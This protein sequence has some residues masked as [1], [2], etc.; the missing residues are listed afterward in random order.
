MTVRCSEREVFITFEIGIFIFQKR[1]DSLQGAFIHPPE[2][3]EGRFVTDA[4]TLFH[5][6]RTGSSKHPC[7]PIERLGGAR[8]IFYITPI[9][10]VWKKKVTYIWDASK[11]SKTQPNFHFWWTNPLSMCFKAFKIYYSLS[12]NFHFQYMVYGQKVVNR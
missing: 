8:T 10:F 7:I 1:M 6:F 12:W 11:G 3:C 5:V 2:P 4:C 9:G